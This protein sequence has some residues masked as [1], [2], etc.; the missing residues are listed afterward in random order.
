MGWPRESHPLGT[1]PKR[2]SV[3]SLLVIAMGLAPD[4][5]AAGERA[6][7]LSE[8]RLGIFD[9]GIDGPRS[10]GG[11]AVN[12]EVLLTPIGAP[13]EGPILDILLRPRPMLGATI[14][15]QG[16][17]S[18]GY[19]GLAWTIPLLTDR[20]FAE[21][22]FGAAVHDGPLDAPGVAS[23]GCAWAFRES[24]S[25]GVAI[26]EGWRLM[27]TVEHMSNADLCARNRGLTNAGVRLGYSLD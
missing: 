7:G 12:A 10:E 20:L 14:N 9:Q 24:L 19:A 3:V 21:T 23:Y 11:V 15:T 6:F 13:A 22:S 18:V 4:L 26:A 16:D 25:L 5:A 17:T 27:G 8:L 1:M 2:I